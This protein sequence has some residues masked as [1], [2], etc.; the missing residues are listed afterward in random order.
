ME[1]IVIWEMPDGQI[2]PIIFPSHGRK[3]GEEDQQWIDRIA[4]LSKPDPHAVRLPDSTLSA[5]PGKRFRNCWRAKAGLVE[6]DLPSARMQRINEIRKERDEKFAP[7]DAEWMK[8]TGQKNTVRAEA[9]EVHRQILRDITVK[10]LADL[11]KLKT[12]EKI[13]VYRPVWPKL[14][15]A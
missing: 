2:V 6:V 9:I 8:A 13:G 1:K 12:P 4:L 10:A 5:L 3:E 14:P 15:V 11:L 7:M